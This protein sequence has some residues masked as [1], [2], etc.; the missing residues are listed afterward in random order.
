MSA[1][2]TAGGNAI[3]FQVSNPSRDDLVGMI[4]WCSTTNGFAPGPATQVYNGADLTLQIIG[5]AAGT[6]HYVRYALLS[7]IDPTDYDVSAQLTAT[8]VASAAPGATVGATWGTNVLGAPANLT[9]LAGTEEIKNDLVV[10]GGR[11]LAVG[12]SNGNGWLYDARDG[13]EFRVTRSATSETGYIYSNQIT[14]DPSEEVTLSFESMQIGVVS[15]CDLYFLG[16]S[17]WITGAI[18]SINYPLSSS[19]I[20]NK[21]GFKLPSTFHGEPITI[22]FDH[23]GGDGSAS[24]VCVRK[25]KLEYGNKATDW[26]PPVEDVAAGIATAA[27]TA[28]WSGVAAVPANLATAG[29]T[30]AVSVLNSAIALA[31]DGTLTG[32]GASAQVSL[33]SIPGVLQTTHLG[34]FTMSASASITAGTSSNGVVIDGLNKRIC[35]FSGGIER[36]RLGYG[37]GVGAAYGLQVKSSAGKVMLDTADGV[38]MRGDVT[39]D[40]YS[41]GDASTGGIDATFG[42]RNIAIGT[43]A[44]AT[45]GG[46]GKQENI[47]IGTQAL[48]LCTDAG[49]NVAIGP[50]TLKNVTTG[51]GNVAICSGAGTAITTANYNISIGDNSLSS[52]GLASVGGENVA[53]GSAA[54]Q[55]AAGNLCRS[56]T[57]IGYAAGQNITSGKNSIF[58]YQAG[59]GLSAEENTII[60]ASAG[61]V[62]NSGNRNVLLGC[63]SGSAL[64]ATTR[65]VVVLG[66]NDGAG[67]VNNAIILSDGDGNIKA[68]ANAA[69]DW[70]FTGSMRTGSVDGGSSSVGFYNRY[71]NAGSATNQYGYY[72]N[73]MCS[74]SCIATHYGA[75]IGLRGAAG[76]AAY[77]TT[78]VQNVRISNYAKG[79]NQTVT[80]QYGFYIEPLTAGTTNWGVYQSGSANKNYFAGNLLL[81]TVTDD[82]VNQLQV[83]GDASLTGK[84]AAAS[85]LAS[86]TGGVGYAT[87]AGGAVMQPTSKATAV[88]L[89]KASG[90]V[91]LNAASLAA[92]A[93]VSFTLTN[94]T[95][96][97]TDVVTACIAS[98]ATAGAYLATVDAVAAGSCRVSLRN[99]SAAALAEAV[100]LNFALVKAVSA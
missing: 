68:T 93:V 84:V 14:F 15:N 32:G 44:L 50:Y 87:G 54:M 47:G 21:F 64:P 48:Q 37:V 52:S 28:A 35:V 62:A 57:V 55:N 19:W 23:N 97:A 6:A 66:S 22:R 17:Y 2:L 83:A 70:D 65:A 99:L 13:D 1:T 92:G 78:G 43:Q 34:A 20:K 49:Y 18:S 26:T 89:N 61:S 79:T 36:V 69:G 16:E 80:V 71:R 76:S 94:S 81:G 59:I 77:T 98:G 29:A 67:A 25:I 8:P 27:T 7:E 85:L 30:P 31:A 3:T 56:N 95:I 12:S 10:V 58:G 91:T 45:A 40:N 63:N 86:G 90:K 33:T 72:E 24:T 39:Q 42:Y 11:N 51:D 73:G 74:E 88:T 41:I 96:A 46:S 82:G 4:V 100:V 5:L 53:M 38:L 60:G 9:A 75:Y